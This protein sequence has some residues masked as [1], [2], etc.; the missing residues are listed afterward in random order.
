MDIIHVGLD[1]G[2]KEAVVR[3]AEMFTD[4]NVSALARLALKMMSETCGVEF[5]KYLSPREAAHAIGITYDEM[6]LHVRAG[7]VPAIKDGPRYRVK[8]DD[9]L[10][11]AERLGEAE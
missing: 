7:N 8:P 1:T 2:Q 4:G 6:M 9:I 10:A 5:I 11:L 3:M